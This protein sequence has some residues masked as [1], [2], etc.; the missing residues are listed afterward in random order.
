M[1]V[2]VYGTGHVHSP[3]QRMTA[4][5]CVL[6]FTC[7]YMRG[8]GCSCVCACVPCRRNREYVRMYEGFG[9]CG[10]CICLSARFLVHVMRPTHNKYI[11]VQI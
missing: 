6:Y 7:A 2:C 1:G 8:R 11:C 9:I 5:A 4:V 10:V 3:G